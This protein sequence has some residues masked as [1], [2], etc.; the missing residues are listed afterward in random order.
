MSYLSDEAIQA[1]HLFTITA[2][3]GGPMES[4]QTDYCGPFQADEEGNSQVLTVIDT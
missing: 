2:P 3:G 1:R 4:L